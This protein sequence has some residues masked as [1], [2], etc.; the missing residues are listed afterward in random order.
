M[1]PAYTLPPDAQH[2]TIMRTL[3]KETMSREHVDTLA[4]G[5]RRLAQVKEMMS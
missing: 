1:V 5:R 4:R 2:V 3:V